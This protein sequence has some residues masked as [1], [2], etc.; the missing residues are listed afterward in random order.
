MALMDFES[1]NLDSNHTVPNDHEFLN[2][3]VN[4]VKE[5]TI[6]YT[7]SIKVNYVTLN[8]INNMI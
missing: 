6:P 1:M 4:N 5:K 8:E 7:N 2:L 3:D